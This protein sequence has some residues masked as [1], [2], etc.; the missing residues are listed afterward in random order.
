MNTIIKKRTVHADRTLSNLDPI[1]SKLFVA[2][3]ISDVSELDHALARLLPYHNLKGIEAAVLGLYQ[4]LE[5]QQCVVVVGDFDAD[6]AT[7]S[8]LA[9]TALRAFGLEQVHYLVPNRFAYGY[10]LTPE[11]VALAIERYQPQLIVTVDNGVSSVAGVALAK[12]Q[13]VPVIVT[14]HHLPGETLPDTLAMVN[15]NQP[16]DSFGSKMLAGVGVIFYVMLA[17]RAHLR[18]TGWFKRTGITEPSMA[19]WLDWV[20]LGTVADVVPLDHNNRILVQHGLMRIRRGQCS[21]GI[22]ALLKVAQCNHFEDLT[23]SDVAFKI[24]PRLNAAGRL[25]DMSLGIACL[26]ESDFDQALSHASA[27]DALNRERR[28]IEKEMQNQAFLALEKLELKAEG[29]ALGLCLF[30]PD[31]HQGVIGILAA[32]IKDTFHRPVVV[33]TQVEEDVLK[34]SARSV[35]GVPICDVLAHIEKARPGLLINFGGHAMAAGL[36]L[37]KRDYKTFARLFDQE[38]KRYLTPEMMQPVL[39]TDGVLP[40]DYFSVPFAEKLGRMI[41]FGQHFPEPLFEGTFLI[42]SQELVGH[43]HVKFMLKVLGSQ[44]IVPAIAFFVDLEKWPNWRCERVYMVYQLS[45]NHYRGVRTLQL[46][47]R[48]LEACAS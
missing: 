26:L 17:L 27:L 5:Q 10:G 46:L 4:A 21:I 16:G 30:N 22:R 29:L 13:G 24:A 42:Q 3:G 23:A 28:R 9:V 40:T 44:R 31:W 2:R 41:P 33:F 20:A 36:T 1:L 19:Q 8:A 6:G 11:I 38:V 45:I 7:S 48:H 43:H 12:K 34:A 39:H 47:V 35:L 32:R 37:C 18:Q 25:K 15:P 14:D